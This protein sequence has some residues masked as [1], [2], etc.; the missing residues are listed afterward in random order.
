MNTKDIA[1]AVIDELIVHPTQQPL[2]NTLRPLIEAIAEQV[3]EIL[4]DNG[5]IAACQH[6]VERQVCHWSYPEETTT[7]RECGETYSCAVCREAVER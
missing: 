7:C 3:R 1:T 2:L 6:C 4:E 5:R